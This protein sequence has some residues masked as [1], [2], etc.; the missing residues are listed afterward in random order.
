M[1]TRNKQDLCLRLVFQNICSE[2]EISLHFSLK[3]NP[4]KRYKKN[5]QQH[6]QRLQHI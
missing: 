1:Q 3:L 6:K 2:V 4:A 5:G